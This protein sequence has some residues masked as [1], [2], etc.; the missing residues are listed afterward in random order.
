MSEQ[1]Y[2]ELAAAF[3]RGRLA[4]TSE[5]ADLDALIRRGRA[6]GLKLH[7]FKRSAE[8]PRVR[9]V[10]GILRAIAPDRLLDIGSGRG[11]FLWPLV[12]AFPSLH[13]TAID[14]AAGRAADLGA[15]ARG[16]ITRLQAVRMD[17]HA[18][19]FADGSFDVVTM[20]EVLE[21]VAD[22]ARAAAEALRVA[23]GFVVASVPSKPD[24]N[25]EHLRLFDA[26]ALER[27]FQSAGRVQCEYVR[28]HIVMVARA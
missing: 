10:I 19:A 2:R 25:P 14:R 6:A 7:K 12:D 11:T 22:P 28:S 23:R 24:D 9:K 8:L 4:Q 21:H 18:L 13:V 26:R 16:G 5:D 27:L 15:V 17:A 20:L 3:V 1:Y